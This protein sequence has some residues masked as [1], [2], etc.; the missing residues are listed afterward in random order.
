MT[1]GTLSFYYMR[2]FLRIFCKICNFGVD[3][4]PIMVLGLVWINLCLTRF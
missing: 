3:K 1:E 2:M 4:L